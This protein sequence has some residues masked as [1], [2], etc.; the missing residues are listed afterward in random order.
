ML[1]QQMQTGSSASSSSMITS[2]KQEANNVEIRLKNFQLEAA[3]M[4]DQLNKFS[5]TK[6][7]DLES[8]LK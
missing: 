6:V 8:L 3:L 1:E 2:A 7:A 5:S 4:R